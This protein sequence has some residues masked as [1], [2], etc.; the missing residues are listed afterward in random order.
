M[1]AEDDL[2]LLERVAAKDRRAFERLYQ[3]YYPRLFGYILKLTRRSE[4]VEEVLNDVMMAVWAG[5]GR[6]AGRSRPS[7]WIFG[8]AHHTALKALRRRHYALE[9]PEE[10]AGEPVAE[11]EPESLLQRREE[12]DLIGRALARLS[13]E[14]RAVV[15]LTYFHGFSYPEIA[16]ILACPTNTVKTRMFHARRRLREIL[17]QLGMGASASGQWGE[18]S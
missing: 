1:T 14:Q 10:A 9:E 2:V 12:R 3:I 15:E 17:P 11:G 6:F 18:E 16:D 7:S 5:A 13:V 8:I 4:L